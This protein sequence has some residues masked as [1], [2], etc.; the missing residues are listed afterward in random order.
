MQIQVFS[1]HF[2]DASLSCGEHILHWQRQ[3]HQVEVT[4]VFTEFDAT[5][6]SADS[7]SFMEKCGVTTGHQF[8]VQRGLED[9]ASMKALGVD[10]VS[11]L[12]LIDGGFRAEHD[13]PTYSSHDL[14]FAGQILDSQQFQKKLQQVLKQAIRTEAMV[15]VP[16]G[17]G[18]H[19]DH[20]LVRQLVSRMVSPERLFFYVD[21][22]Y[23]FN[24]GNWSFHQGWQ[25]LSGRQSWYWSS[26][27]KLKAVAAYDSQVPILFKEKLWHYPECCIGISL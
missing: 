15:G 14:L 3:G 17:V 10:R 22:P 8:H 16:L 4:T 9:Q 27:Q 2:D 23:A 19:A 1:P 7:A 6:F 18:R 11:W 26:P 21:V 25:L 13:Q 24:L 12:G 5:V 20:L